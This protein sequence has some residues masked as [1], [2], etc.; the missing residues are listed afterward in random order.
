MPKH[1]GRRLRGV[2]PAAQPNARK[3]WEFPS[4]VWALL[5]SFTDF[6]PHGQ[7]APRCSPIHA[8]SEVPSPSAFCQSRGATYL[9][10]APSP[11]VKLRPQGFAPSRRLAPPATFRACF[12]PVPLLGFPFEACPSTVPYALS[13]AGP[14]RFSTR[15]SWTGPPLQGSGTPRRSCT[16]VWGLARLPRRCLLGIGHFEASCSGRR[17]PN[18]QLTSPLAL[19]RVGRVLTFPLAPQGLYQPSRSRSLSRSA[20]LLGVFRLVVL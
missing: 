1:P 9:R 11:P 18:Y 3:R 16:R 6:T 8:P 10:R 7:A 20:C 4:Q 13:S 17:E 5:H 14:L 12:I 15:S 19:L 2:H